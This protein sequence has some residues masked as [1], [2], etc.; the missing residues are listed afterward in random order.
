MV[1]SINDLVKGDIIYIERLY[2]NTKGVN[3]I[4]VQAIGRLWITLSHGIRLDKQTL[5]G[6]MI[7]GYL[8]VTD[9]EKKVWVDLLR[10]RIPKAVSKATPE[11]LAQIAEILGVTDAPAQQA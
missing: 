2:S 10:Q 4:E 3:P 1:K 11:Q 6:D 7:H 9:Y 8:E 5:R